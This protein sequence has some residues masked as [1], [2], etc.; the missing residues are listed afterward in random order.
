MSSSNDITR[1]RES[2]GE[3]VLLPTT[4]NHIHPTLISNIYSSLTS[5]EFH[6]FASWLLQQH[7]SWHAGVSNQSYAGNTQLC[8][9]THI[10]ALPV[11]TCQ[12]SHQRPI[13]L[14]TSS[15]SCPFQVY[16][17]CV[18]SATQHRS[19]IHLPILC[20]RIYCRASLRAQIA[21]PSQH[22]L[23]VPATK[24]EFEGRSFTVAGPSTWNSLPDFVKDVELLDIFKARL[25][26][27]FFRKSYCVWHFIVKAPL[28]SRSRPYS[29][30]SFDCEYL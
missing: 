14:A 1:P 9:T 25:K 19:F 28:T 12:I 24:T 27:H 17:A 6:H 15:T 2:D 20:Q 30:A 16:N 21:A 7:F 11:R 4:T 8:S 18:Q 22:D 13:A 29:I 5:E 26:T 10:R 3:F 23:V